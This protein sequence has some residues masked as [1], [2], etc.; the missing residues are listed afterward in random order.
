MTLWQMKAMEKGMG[1][2]MS[3]YGYGATGS[4]SSIPAFAPLVFEIELVEKPED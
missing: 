3:G 4:G 2:F 1:V